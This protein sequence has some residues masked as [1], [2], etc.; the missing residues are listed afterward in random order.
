MTK[1][2]TTKWNESDLERLKGEGKIIGYTIQN[3]IKEQPEKKRKRAKFNNSKV[4]Y[5]G[6][7]FDSKKE[8]NRYRELL[9]LLKAGEIGMLKRQV[10]YVLIEKN[11]TERECAYFAD[12]E[13]LDSKT[14][15]RIVED[16]KSEATKKLSTYILKRKLMK[17][18][19]NIEI[20]E[21]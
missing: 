17:S 8:Y 7:I 20:K 14:G 4:E 15:K 3:P 10:K 13:Y 9:L 6:M 2:A 21:T 16:T 12:F 18:K 1:K 19:F 5:E 11:E